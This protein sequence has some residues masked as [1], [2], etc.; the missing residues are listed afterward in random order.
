MVEKKDA[1]M[2]AKGSI[3]LKFNA[4]EVALNNTSSCQSLKITV[5]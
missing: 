1:R 2:E 5:I 4:F 3:I